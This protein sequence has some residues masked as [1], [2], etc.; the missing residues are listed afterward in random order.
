LSLQRIGVVIGIGIGIET[1]VDIDLDAD[2][3]PE[4]MRKS[5]IPLAAIAG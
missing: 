5:R 1:D 3:N 4:V 2:P